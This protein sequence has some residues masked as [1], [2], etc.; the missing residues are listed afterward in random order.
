M[1]RKDSLQKYSLQKTKSKAR[2]EGS[3]EGDEKI[4]ILLDRDKR[5][6][7][8][9]AMGSVD[10]MDIVGSRGDGKK[11]HSE[12]RTRWM[13]ERTAMSWRSVGRVD[14]WSWRSTG[15]SK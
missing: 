11:K 2:K 3:K 7:A 15:E 8:D 10:P 5:W 12:A 1:E 9:P 14:D 4:M 6:R 13:L